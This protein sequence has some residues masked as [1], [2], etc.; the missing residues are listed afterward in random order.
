[1]PE[2]ITHCNRVNATEMKSSV[3]VELVEETQESKTRGK[4]LESKRKLFLLFKE[5]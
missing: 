3:V 2:T 1:M 4:L 5:F